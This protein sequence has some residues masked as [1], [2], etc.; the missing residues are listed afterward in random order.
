LGEDE[1]VDEEAVAAGGE[2]RGEAVK[3]V[4]ELD[5]EGGTNA[6]LGRGDEKK[7]WLSMVRREGVRRELNRSQTPVVWRCAIT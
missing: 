7:R 4:G 1:E 3:V 6:A 5:D 2:M